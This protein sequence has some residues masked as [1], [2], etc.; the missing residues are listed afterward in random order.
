[1]TVIA[2]DNRTLKE[3]VQDA[4]RA[5]QNDFEPFVPSH[6]QIAMRLRP[7]VDE[8]LTLDRDAVKAKFQAHIDAHG[9]LTGT[10][11]AHVLAEV[12]SAWALEDAPVP[13]AK[14]GVMRWRRAV[15]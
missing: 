6:S 2:A 12:R 15:R 7:L 4:I 9:P 8:L 13:P 1:M 11:V 3:R 5:A 14:D 10:W